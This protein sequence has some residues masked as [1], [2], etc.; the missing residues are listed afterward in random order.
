MKFDHAAFQVSDIKRSIDFYVNKL[1]FKLLFSE[2][3]KEEQEAFAFL[4]NGDARIELIQDLA[5]PYK[6]PAVKRPYCPHFCLETKDMN[7]TVK[8][9]KGNNINIVRGPLE[10]KREETWI[11]FSD[12]DNNILEFIHW[13]RKK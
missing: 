7:Q 3:N 10:I 5:E 2:V 8:M 9:L 6:I 1:G 13:F 11:Y 4:V 12:P